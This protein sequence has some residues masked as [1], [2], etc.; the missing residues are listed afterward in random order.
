[1]SRFKLSISLT[2]EIAQSAICNTEYFSLPE[3]KKIHKFLKIRLFLS[4]EIRMSINCTLYTEGCLT[5]HNWQ[6]WKRIFLTCPCHEI[7]RVDEVGFKKFQLYFKKLW[8][9]VN[10]WNLGQFLEKFIPKSKNPFEFKV[11]VHSNL[12]AKCNQF[13]PL[14]TNRKQIMRPRILSP[15]PRKTQPHRLHTSCTKSPFL[16]LGLGLGSRVWTRV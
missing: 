9:F 15:S 2:P 14:N 6:K 1:M 10:M 12:W 4:L 8:L 3:Q 13:W 16:S 5:A 7:Y 11:T